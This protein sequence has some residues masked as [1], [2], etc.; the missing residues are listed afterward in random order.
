MIPQD[1][2]MSS[3]RRLTKTAV[4]LVKRKRPCWKDD[5]SST[6]RRNISRSLQQEE[7][8]LIGCLIRKEGELQSKH[9][10]Q[11]LILAQLASHFLSHV[12]GSD[13]WSLEE[14][15][16]LSPTISPLINSKGTHS[17]NTYPSIPGDLHEKR[18]YVRI[19]HT[20]GSKSRKCWKKSTYLL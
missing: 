19:S 10:H 14:T 16:E 8:D 7:D 9:G 13:T 1:I 3:D 18:L 2:S 6:H 17:I 5:I 11:I 12:K 4:S 20:R 15:R